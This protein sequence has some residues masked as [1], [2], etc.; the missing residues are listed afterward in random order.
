MAPQPS[1][2]LSPVTPENISLTSSSPLL[3]FFLLSPPRSHLLYIM[4][5]SLT[6][7]SH[8]PI[9]QTHFHLNENDSLVLTFPEF[10]FPSPYAGMSTVTSVQYGPIIKHLAESPL[11]Y[12]LQELRRL[13]SFMFL[14]GG[15]L[16]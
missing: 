7:C 10:L 13:T 9:T 3:L 15:C 6:R 2:H 4:C 1:N 11:S 5:P 12:I 16:E 8:P 14:R